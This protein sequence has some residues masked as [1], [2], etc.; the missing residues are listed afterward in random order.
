MMEITW[1]DG[2]CI[3]ISVATIAVLIALVIDGIRW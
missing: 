3:A 2:V 1:F